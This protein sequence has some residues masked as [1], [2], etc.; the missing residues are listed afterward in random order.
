[1]SYGCYLKRRFT[2]S[3]YVEVLS[4]TLQTRS[5]VRQSSDLLFPSSLFE[6]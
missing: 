1:M 6:N 4:E 5:I 3:Q 2:E